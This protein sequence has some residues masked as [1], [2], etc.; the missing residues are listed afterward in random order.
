MTCRACSSWRR[1][2][3]GVRPSSRTV[4][5]DGT[6]ID[7]L[8]AQIL[9]HRRCSNPTAVWPGGVGR[10]SPPSY[11]LVGRALL[12]RSGGI[13]EGERFDA[14]VDHVASL[15]TDPYTAADALLADGP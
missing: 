2:R 4:A 10:G 7:E 12:T 14:L 6:G 1:A 3:R 11:A 15:V 5:T 13:T 9:A 8:W